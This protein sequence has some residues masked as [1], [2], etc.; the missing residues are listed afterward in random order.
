VAKLDAEYELF[1]LELQEAALRD[2]CQI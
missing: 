1:F 2:G